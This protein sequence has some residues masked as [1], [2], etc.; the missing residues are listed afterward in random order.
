MDYVGRS[1]IGVDPDLGLDEIGIP[2]E[3]AWKLYS[4]YIQR[5]LVRNGMSPEQAVKYIADRHEQASRALDQEMGVRP[6]VY[7]RQ[8]SWHKYNVVGGWPKRIP[9]NMIRI[10]ALV[11]TRYRSRY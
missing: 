9:G 5:R 4:P 2:N 10:N 7:G 8:P 3:M 1:V 6:V 11:T